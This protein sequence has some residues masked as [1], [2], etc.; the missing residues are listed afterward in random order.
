M[1]KKVLLI[2]DDQDIHLHLKIIL[3]K[4]GYEFLS[5][6]DGDS[7]LDVYFSANPDLVILDYLMPVKDGV[8]VFHELKERI[9]LRGGQECPV[10]FLTAS[11]Q[12]PQAIASIL[13][14]GVHAYLKKPFGPSELLNIID[15]TFVTHS[16]A[17]RNR[18]LQQAIVESRNFLENLV[19]SCPVCIFT[20][21]VEGHIT[22]TSKAVEDLLDYPGHELMGRPIEDI[23]T[24]DRLCLT[25]YKSSDARIKSYEVMVAT[26]SGRG[27]PMEFIISQLKNNAQDTQG[28]LV[29][30]KDLS[31]TREL[32]RERLEKERL[33]AIND[34]LATINHQINNPLT[35]IIGNVQLIKNEPSELSQALLEKLDIIESN[36]KKIAEIIKKF[37]KVSELTKRQ[38]YGDVNFLDLN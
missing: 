12:D 25:D 29:V 37:N 4:A 6:L 32:E 14:S 19:E 18:K 24:N 22:F 3:E 26:R 27:V 20:T 15:N 8:R 2:D 31:V 21:D 11:H 16:I 28:Y 13:E 38:Y 7:G 10:I 5:A 1:T 33:T 30:G 36:A 35:P 17:V 23:L 9:A 34:S